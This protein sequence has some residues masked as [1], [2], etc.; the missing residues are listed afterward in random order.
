MKA[1]R[2]QNSLRTQTYFRLSLFSAFLR[3]SA[4]TSDS[5]KYVCVR[6]LQAK[7]SGTNRKQTKV[8]LTASKQK[9]FVSSHYRSKLSNYQTPKMRLPRKEKPRRV[10]AILFLLLFCLE[11]SF[12]TFNRLLVSCVEK[13][14]VQNKKLN[15][16]L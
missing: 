13:I 14:R 1:N 5:R 15:I 7:R 6:R 9:C 16:S 10:I 12:S 11:M 3:F 4:E 2:K 8:E